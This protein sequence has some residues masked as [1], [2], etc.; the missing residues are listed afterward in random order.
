MSILIETLIETILDF[1]T[2][3]INVVSSTSLN[4]YENDS[5]VAYFCASI[6]FIETYK[7]PSKRSA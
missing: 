3:D 2:K 7:N 4:H 6:Q 5:F 1:R